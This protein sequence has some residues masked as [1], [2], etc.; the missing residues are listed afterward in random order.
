MK[1]SIRNK[2]IALFSVILFAALWEILALALNSPLVLPSIEV[3]A[4]RFF[5]L[6]GTKT[7]WRSLGF[8]F[9]RV[10]AAFFITFILGLLLGFASGLSEKVRVFLVFPLSLI[11]GT[12]V[13]ALIMVML[14][15]FNS[16]SL[17]VICAVLMNLPVMTDGVSKA[18]RNT[19]KKLLEMARIFDISFWRK[20]THIYL[21]ET[22]PYIEGAARTVFSQGWKVVAAG[23][24]LALPRNAIGTLI[25]DN[26]LI[27]ESPSVF[28]LTLCLCVLCIV[29]E[30]LFF[31]AFSMCLVVARK[32]HKSSD[33]TDFVKIENDFPQQQ[34]D[35]TVENLSFSYGATNETPG[36][37]VFKDLSLR[38]SGGAIT[39]LF[40][41][42]GR[43]KTTLLKILSGLISSDSY[44]GKVVCPKVSF[45]FQDQRLVSNL[46][47]L[48]NAALPLYRQFGKKEALKKGK[49]FL[50]MVGLLEKEKLPAAVLSGGEKQKLQA[51]RAFAYN[52]PVILMDEGTSS[53]DEKSRSE[54]WETIETL[55]AKNP[56]TLVFV[57]HNN[58]E[59]LAH[60]SQII[61]F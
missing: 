46:S 3:V 60:S 41:P 21:P 30:K 23:E 2:L 45:I 38:L 37:L 31:K 18:V 20:I 54:L 50:S 4:G 32:L 55:M 25:Q 33:G 28:A 15:W 40:A 58:D 16:R 10:L 9:L 17:P 51:A 5:H 52:T 44:Q 6:A 27:L 49:K 1:T 34:S 7:F 57:T 56:R 13:V 29:S 19:D 22:R 59:A 36:Q 61:E 24:I 47:V 8:T 39:A 53:L 26:R 48:E 42:T 14:F 43:G 12:P 11:R 35:I